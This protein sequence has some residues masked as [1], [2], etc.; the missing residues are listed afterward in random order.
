ML[1]NDR[2]VKKQAERLASRLIAASDDST[3]RVEY[4]WQIVFQR[5]ATTK[6]LAASVEYVQR[7][8]QSGRLEVEVWTSLSRAV[9]NS[10]ECIFVD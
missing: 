6:E 5:K 9:L 10:N 8:L 3:A 4:L 2:F 7:Q 1:L